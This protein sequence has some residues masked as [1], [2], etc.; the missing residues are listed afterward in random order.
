MRNIHVEIDYST[1]STRTFSLRADADSEGR[2]LGPLKFSVTVKTWIQGEPTRANLSEV[3]LSNGDGALDSFANETMTAVRIYNVPIPGGTRTLLAAGTPDR[4]ILDGHRAL[5][6]TI[7]DARKLLD[8]PLQSQYYPTSETALSDG[9]KTNTYYGLEDV[10]RP[11]CVG[12]CRSVPGVVVNRS[13]NEYHVHSGV[14]NGV[15]TVYD[16][17]ISVTFTG[18]DEGFTLA[19]N[20]SGRIVADVEGQEVSGGGD[21]LRTPREVVD[22]IMSEIG[23]TNY[24]TGDLDD[25]HGSYTPLLGFYQDSENSIN[26]SNLLQWIVDSWTGWFYTGSDGEVRFGYLKEPEVTPDVSLNRF[27]IIGRINVFDDLAKGLKIRVG[28]ARNWYVYNQDDIVFGATAQD[29]IDL[30]LQHRIVRTSATSI[31]PFY[32]TTDEVHDTLLRGSGNA[33][34]EVDNICTLYSTKRRFLVFE[35]RTGAAIGETVEVDYPRFGLAGGVNFLCVGYEIDFIS[36]KYKL[37]LWG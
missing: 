24:N 10:P 29:K 4:A 18:F 30:A 34:D 2:L 31:D 15:N 16:D 23:F 12:L 21:Y 20:P 28:A 3:N 17:G 35:S 22:Y 13:I 1:S 27:D 36:N 8:V 9:S 7:Q 11:W 25:I 26:V 32:S 37:Y 14:I 5:K 19:A 6:I 33:Q